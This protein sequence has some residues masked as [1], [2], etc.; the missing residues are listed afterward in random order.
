[1]A[2]SS[3][4]RVV[5]FQ[6]LVETLESKEA[7]GNLSLGLL[8]ES[9]PFGRPSSKLAAPSE[10]RRSLF[11]LESSRAG[12]A[13][14]SLADQL[15]RGEPVVAERH[16]AV[17]QA[18]LR[19]TP[20]PHALQ[21]VFGEPDDPFI[22]PL[23]LLFA[24]RR[25]PT[26][27]VQE[28]AGLSASTGTFVVAPTA[29]NELDAGTALAPA[30]AGEAGGAMVVPL[31]VSASVFVAAC[32]AALAEACGDTAASPSAEPNSPPA[33]PDTQPAD[34]AAASG[35]LQERT[36]RAASE[37]V[38]NS[39]T[40]PQGAAVSGSQET[41]EEE[42][43]STSTAKAEPAGK[44]QAVA[45]TVPAS[46]AAGGTG[47]TLAFVTAW[48]VAPG[49]QAEQA[50]PPEAAPATWTLT[51]SPAG[52]GPRPL[53]VAATGSAALTLAFGEG[54]VLVHSSHVRA[55]AAPAA[56]AVA[57]RPP[58]NLTSAARL[59]SAPTSAPPRR[60]LAPSVKAAATWDVRALAAAQE[61]KTR[62]PQ[63]LEQ[64]A[65]AERTTLALVFTDIVGSTSLGC[66]LGNE[67]MDEVRRA[68]F[69]RG[70][71][72]LAKHGGFEIKTLGDSLMV[73][74]RTAGAALD[75]SREFCADP[76]HPFLRLRA[77]VHVGPVRIEEND[78]YGMMVNYTARIVAE[79][80][81]EQVWVSDRAHEE[82]NEVHA[83]AHRDLEWTEH[84]ECFLKGFVG[85]QRLWSVGVREVSN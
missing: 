49:P 50:A 84:S 81:P 4:S 14:S 41:A 69:R 80:T 30:P 26:S 19:E 72:L 8:T 27:G 52:D 21:S 24:P 59:G 65:G 40:E 75:F 12:A 23:E 33:K 74:F 46:Q 77:G 47:E 85:G 22:S 3:P 61:R 43:K 31:V 38:A 28:D 57:A 32:E 63:R 83:R 55:A 13:F 66:E 48:A 11:V 76:G 45:I 35:K 58:D 7:P 73:A 34:A 62:R 39:A 15:W 10:V 25:A 44:Q 18:A 29:R 79:A 71:L 51:V 82:I 36:Q 37:L 20:R 1:M 54:I 2:R 70:R 42:T 78:A 6:P 9:E 60:A 17:R 16:A 53:A 64:W 5:G 56:P 67:A 68:H